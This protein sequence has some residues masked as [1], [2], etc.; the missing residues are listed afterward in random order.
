MPNHKTSGCQ[1]ARFN[2]VHIAC[3]SNYK[4]CQKQTYCDENMPRANISIAHK[5]KCKHSHLAYLPTCE[6][7]SL[8][9]TTTPTMVGGP[10]E[11]GGTKAFKPLVQRDVIVSFGPPKI[12]VLSLKFR[13]Q[14]PANNCFVPSNSKSFVVPPK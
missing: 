13:L 1:Q 12:I 14:S 3:M 10:K 11:F 7:R 4:I 9:S 5:P 2:P 8:K 6:S